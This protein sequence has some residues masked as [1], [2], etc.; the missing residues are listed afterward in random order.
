LEYKVKKRGVSK[1]RKN[2]KMKILSFEKTIKQK[3]K[4]LPFL[5]FMEIIAKIPPLSPKATLMTVNMR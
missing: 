3:K 4:E 2:R 1:K 5:G